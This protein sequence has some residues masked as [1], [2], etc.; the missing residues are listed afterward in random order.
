V[1]QL[2][3]ENVSEIR[4]KQLMKQKP[5]ASYVFSLVIVAVMSSLTT[6]I[7]T[8]ETYATS[9]AG[10]PVYL[11][12]AVT[13]IDQERLPEYQAIAG[14]L[15]GKTGGYVPLAHAMPNMIEGEVP[16]G[17]SYFIERYDSLEGLMAFVNSPEFQEAKK[18]RDEI[19]DVHFMMWLPAVPPGSL[20][21]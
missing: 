10:E 21:H 1:W 9:E 16:T 6:L 13:V 12:G 3:F 20:P 19:A 7:V 17:G 15:A 14:P 8:Q 11:I 18:L 4:G 2:I 5:S